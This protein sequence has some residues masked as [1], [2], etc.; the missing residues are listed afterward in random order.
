METKETKLTATQL[1][2]S[3]SDVLNRV[4][5]K[6]ERFTV[7]RNGRPVATLIPAEVQPKKATVGDLIELFNTLPRPDSA[8]ADDLEA[9]QA[10]QPLAETPEWPS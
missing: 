5:Y 10:A 7:E 6:G 2:R 1:A 8:L 3:L 4:Q 9:I